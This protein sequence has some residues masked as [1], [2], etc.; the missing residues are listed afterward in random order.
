MTEP[1]RAIVLIVDDSETN[2][3]LA[4]DLLRAANVSTL[5]A[6]RGEDAVRLAAEHVPDIVL[7]DLQLPDIDGAEVARR[8]ARDRRTA[9]IPIVAL[10]AQPL[11]ASRKWL[12]DAGFAG[13]LEKPLCVARFSSQVLAYCV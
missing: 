7:L 13:F 4:R 6:G 5:E 10:S 11:E 2:R 9:G 12:A 1:R 3:K 8:L